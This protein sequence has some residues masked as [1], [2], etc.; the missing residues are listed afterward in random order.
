ATALQGPGGRVHVIGVREG[1][2]LTEHQI[3]NASDPG[4]CHLSVLERYGRGSAP[5]NG[6]VHG[7][8]ES[9]RGAIASSVGHDSH[10]LISV[11]TDTKDMKVAW[12]SLKECGGGFVVVKG[13]RV[14][15][16]LSLPFGGLMSVRDESALTAEL[17]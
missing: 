17:I 12:E 14:L 15:A 11:G 16:R 9:F 8:G 5:A 6:Y 10:N 13:G 4:V 1:K 2:I 3:R 7:F